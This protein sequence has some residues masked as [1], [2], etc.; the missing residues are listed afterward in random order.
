MQNPTSALQTNS[1]QVLS[2]QFVYIMGRGHSGSTV[3]DALLGNHTDAF[4]IGELVSGWRRYDK[5]CS[6]GQ[7]LRDCPVWSAIREHYDDMSDQDW[8]KT[9]IAAANQARVKKFFQV[10]L[11]SSRNRGLCDLAD[12]T[13][14]VV[15]SICEVTGKSVIIDSSKEVT[16]GLF[17]ARFLKSSRI[18]HLVRH[19]FSI[20]ASDRH[21]IRDGTGYRFQRRTIHGKRITFP[22][23]M[24]SAAS[25]LV[26]G[27]LA[28]IVKTVAGKRMLRIRYEDLCREPARTLNKMGE[29]LGLD[30]TGVSKMV[31]DLHPFDIGH[32]IAG[33]RMRLQDS[34]TFDPS[35]S[36]SRKLPLI[37]RLFTVAITW[38][39]LL[40]YGYSWQQPT[41]DS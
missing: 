11:C 9:G 35:R 37:Y 33:N 10:L 23:M 34:F 38:P 15:R 14:L 32:K 5:P 12:A 24:L 17:I 19:P 41:A 30:M 26:G 25:W 29:F 8:D 4:G 40:L 3:V 36:G 16:R 20:L 22:L 28:G 39:L 2:A 13:N 7:A 31:D 6:C 18:I 21:R 1:N 27:L